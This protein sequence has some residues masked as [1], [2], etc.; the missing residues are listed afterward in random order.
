MSRARSKKPGANS[1]IERRDAGRGAKRS[2]ARTDARGGALT[3]LGSDIGAVLDLATAATGN[4]ELATLRLIARLLVEIAK[5]V[6][7]LAKAV[8]RKKAGRSRGD[9]AAEQSLEA[10]LA[11]LRRIASS[12]G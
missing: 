1:A 12:V 6:E 4:A 7:A 3:R 11:E 2:T 10:L 9:R 5:L 8:R